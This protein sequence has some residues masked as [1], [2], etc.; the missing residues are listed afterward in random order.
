MMKVKNHKKFPK[1]DVRN[2]LCLALGEEWARIGCYEPVLRRQEMFPQRG[3]LCPP[4]SPLLFPTLLP[5]TGGD[6]TTRE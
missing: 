6:V 5:A 4:S 2:S 3:N 1:I